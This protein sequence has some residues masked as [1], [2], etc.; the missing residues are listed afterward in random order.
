MT[1]HSMKL[2]A[3]HEAGHAVVAYYLHRRIRHVSII[4]SKDELGHMLRGKGPDLKS[5]E[6]E[7]SNGIRDRLED[8]AMISWGGDAAEFIL[9][10]RKKYRPGS[11]SDIH[12]VVEYLS[13]ICGEPEA[14]GAY[15][16]W[17]W[18]CTRNLLREENQWIAV[19]ALAVELIKKRYI[20]G[21]RT[22]QI[23]KNTIEDNF[24]RKISKQKN[25]KVSS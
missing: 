17:L 24:Q 18:Y 22:R 5:A 25:Q 12:S 1:E 16:D 8:S 11:T 20:G 19:E 23:I 14:L 21:T 4:Q 7:I 9:T 10:N 6:W 13:K 2:T 3:Y 15:V